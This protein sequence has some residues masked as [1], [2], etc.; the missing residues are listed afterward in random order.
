MLLANCSAESKEDE[1][2]ICV[3][4]RAVADVVIEIAF[5]AE[6]PTNLR[7]EDLFCDDCVDDEENDLIG[8]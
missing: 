3:I 5:L 6:E 1:E 7:R 4:T 2:C 8:G